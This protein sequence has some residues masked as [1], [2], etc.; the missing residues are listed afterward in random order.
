MR[1]RAGVLLA[2]GAGIILMLLAPTRAQDAPERSAAELMDVLMWN[3]EPVGGP[4]ALVD[5]AGR[6][7]TEKDFQGKLLLVYFGFT[8][9]PDLCPTDLQAIGLALD[10]LG[11]AG[12]SVQ[13][14][15]ITVDPERDTPAHLADYVPFFHPR[16]IGLSGDP[17][18]IRQVARAY[19]V[20]YAKTP[21]TDGS[22]YTVDHS[23]YVYLMDRAGQ[24][25]GFFPPGTPPDRMVDVI[26]PLVEAR[27][28]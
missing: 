10:R 16:L 4:F 22:D 7:R 13:P 9:C 18:A 3:R 24:Y 15:F 14:L 25:L 19:K 2:L 1:R 27:G 26:R 6:P 12:E 17:A 21:R 11:E 5:Q 28:G 20:F 23:G 8:F